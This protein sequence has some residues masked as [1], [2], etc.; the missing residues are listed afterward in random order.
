MKPKPLTLGLLLLSVMGFVAGYVLSN[1]YSFGICVVNDVSCHL[2][3]ERL[4]ESLFYG[5]GALALVFGGLL[6]VPKAFSAWWKFAIWFVPLALVIFVTAPEPQGWVS[7]I[8]APQVIFQWV[9]GLYVL[10]S[11]VLISL[12]VKKKTQISSLR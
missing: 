6:F 11:F 9:S 3:F 4:G 5:M 12:N 2:T 10:V 1:V 7:P 8:P